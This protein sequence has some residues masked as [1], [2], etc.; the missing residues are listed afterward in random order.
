MS[1]KNAKVARAAEK[2]KGW[3]IDIRSYT[4]DIPIFTAAGRPLEKDGKP[5]IEKETVDVQD[6]LAR[7]LFHTGLQQGPEDMFKAKDLADK[8]RAAKDSILLDK[9]ELERIKKSYDLLK[10]LPEHYIE[11]LRRIRDAEEVQLT[12][13]CSA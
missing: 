5:V 3:K 10:G 9:T 4:V 11:F 1:E 7:M 13:D 8:I 6:N 12:E 2:L